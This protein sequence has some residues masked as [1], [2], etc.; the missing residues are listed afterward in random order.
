MN[1]PKISVIIPTY[2]GA[3]FIGKAIQSVLGQTYP[4]FEL[5]IVNDASPD[6]V[7]DVVEQFRDPRIKYIVHK[8][9]QGVD[10]SRDTGLKASTGEIIAFLDQDDS[11]HPEKLQKHV[12][13]LK[14]H[15]DVG[16]TY[17]ARFELNYSSESIREIWRPPH[18][19]NLADLVLWFPIAPSDW[20]IRREW[21]MR[22]D[23][24]ND[25]AWTG[26]E[27][28]YLSRL[29]LEGCKFGMVNRALNYRRHHT[30]RVFKDL[31]GG[32][33]HELNA[34][35]LVFSDPRCPDQIL[36]LKGRAHANI[37]FFWA[38]RAF[39]QEE[40]EIGQEFVRQMVQHN[41][42]VIEGTTCEF[43]SNLAITCSD[44][45]NQDHVA[46]LKRIFAQLPPELVH[47]NDQID[48]PILRGYL[49]KGTRAFIWGR[50]EDGRKYLKQASLLGAKFDDAYLS[51][52]TSSLLDFE[53][54]FGDTAVQKII[55]EMAP[56][57]KALDGSKCLNRLQSKLA[58]NMAFHSYHSKEYTKVWP[59]VWEAIKWE[60]K[61]LINRGVIAILFCSVV[62]QITHTNIKI[63]KSPITP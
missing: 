63:A 13:Y 17:N 33:E 52:L 51:F 2:N 35:R 26:K 46:L 43:V 12:E 50:P 21:A 55:T 19:I 11:Y 44:D 56:T 36:S 1:S 14:Q 15:P 30:K 18:E 16:F 10:C 37:Y 31:V 38:Y 32:C 61:Y 60:P 6:N 59:K 54:E 4:D 53:I 49:L 29:F 28:V 62:N 57:L 9:N 48:W 27:I 39:A 7:T 5:I 34:Q 25:Y 42:A 8:K 47:L 58:L 3:T 45:E 22:I 40:T 20:V 41:P 23:F 24:V